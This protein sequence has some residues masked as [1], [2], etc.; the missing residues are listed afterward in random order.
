MSAI[1]RKSRAFTL[2]ELL[3]VIGII[4]LLIAILLPS[5]RKAREHAIRTQCLSN[6][7]QIGTACVMYAAENKGWYPARPGRGEVNIN[8]LPHELKHPNSTWDL[9]SSFVLPYLKDRSRMMF[10]VG[11][12]DA[13]HSGTTNYDYRY[14]TYA[15]FNYT[16]NTFA[17]LVPQPD[18][19]RHGKRN[20]GKTALWSCLTVQ[21]TNGQRWAHAGHTLR[22]DFSSMN[23]YFTDGS[24]S[25][26]PGGLD[27]EIFFSS[28]T[29]YYWPIPQP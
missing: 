11:Q 8:Y 16:P 25:W 22:Q 28:A 17:W 10:C 5:L 20:L 14:G 29:Q 27:T 13:R 23:A 18:L 12:L 9:N 24:G 3:V 1:S 15:Y 6:L 21:L 19:T 2:V 4:A 26:V 7:R